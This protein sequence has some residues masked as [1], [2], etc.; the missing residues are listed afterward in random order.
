MSRSKIVFAVLLA[1]ALV[2]AARVAGQQL[3]REARVSPRSAVAGPASAAA[4]GRKEG[5]LKL[6]DVL[7]ALEQRN[8]RLRAVRSVAAAAAARQPEASTLPDPLFQFG[9]MNVGLPDLNADMAMTMAPS[10]QVMQMVPFP[11]K[12]SLKGDIAELGTAM[13]GAGAEETWW[14][15]RSRA[16]DLFYKLYALDRRIEVMRSTL[17]LLEDFGTVAKAMYSAGTGRQA[18]VLRAD[19]EVARMD[20]EIRKMQALRIAAAAR[21]NALLARPAETSVPTPVLGALPLEVPGRDVLTAWAEESRPVLERGRLGVE[22]AEARVKLARKDIWP[23]LT[24]G[25]QYGQRDRGAGTERMGSAIVG[26][27]LPIHAGRRQYAAREEAIAY[28]R[29]AEADLGDL[30]AQV[31][32]RIDELLAELG[33]ARSLV[34]LYRD[35]VLPQARATVESAFSSY[36]V[37]TVDFM[38][39][40][41]AEMTVNRYEGELYQL[42]A[43][44]GTAIAALESA[45]GRPLPESER[46]LAEES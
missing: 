30:R 4:H 44:Y 46:T 20:G 23:N 10:V 7:E 9:A 22:Q 2:P 12:L 25:F 27:T 32:A 42:L 41:D 21:L 15:V 43:D 45:V 6:S 17:G 19:V 29:V 40:V 18:D 24:F 36:R 38:T 26:F 3:D 8:P 1:G 33:Q 11:G 35:E 37:G 39:L 34:R 28:Q 31:G 14:A 16:S 13:A 5:G